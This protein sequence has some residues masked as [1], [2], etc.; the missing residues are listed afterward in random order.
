METSRAMA[1]PVLTIRLPGTPPNPNDRMNHWDRNEAI[2]EWKQMA[3]IASLE[4]RPY[5]CLSRARLSCTFRFPNTRRH[6]FDNLVASLKGAI[7]GLVLAKVLT[8]DTTEVVAGITVD[9]V[10]DPKQPRETILS[11]YRV[12][13]EEA[14]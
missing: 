6:D 1:E 10:T 13:D 7:D 9:A 4:Q 14:V 5:P 2:Q 12:D 3:F 11:V 8:D